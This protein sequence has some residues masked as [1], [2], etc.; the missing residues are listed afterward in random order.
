MTADTRDVL[1]LEAE[2]TLAQVHGLLLIPYLVQT[3]GYFREIAP[4]VFLDCDVDQEWDLLYHRQTHHPAAA[5]RLLDV[6]I[7]ETAFERLNRPDIMAGQLRHL[8]ALSHS[9]HATVCIIPKDAAFF[10][11]R[12]HLFEILSF[13]GTN[14]RIGVAYPAVIGVRL[15]SGDAL[16][17][18]WTHI[19]T[20][21]AADPTESRTILERHLAAQS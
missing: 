19:E 16:Y 5:T 20:T 6:I 8:L 1:L 17:D 18:I 11:S 13:A 15:A 21:V 2:A 10:E 7:D 9:P 12:G 14:D 4:Y 3:E